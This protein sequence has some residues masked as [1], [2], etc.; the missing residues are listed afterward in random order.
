VNKQSAQ[1]SNFT[2]LV[3]IFRRHDLDDD[4]SLSLGELRQSMGALIPEGVEAAAEAT[5]GSEDARVDYKALVAEAARD[6]DGETLSRRL[7]GMGQAMGLQVGL[8]EASTVDVF[9]EDDSWK[10]SLVGRFLPYLT[11]TPKK[12]F[13]SRRRSYGTRVLRPENGL[14]KLVNLIEEN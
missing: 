8:R 1:K 13:R 4:G 12:A 10:I 6:L 14:K 3:Q 11:L 9:M 5:A 7:T 2:Q